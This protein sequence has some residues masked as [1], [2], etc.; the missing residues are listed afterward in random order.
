MKDRAQD[1]YEKEE[2]YSKP[3][4]LV[5]AKCAALTLGLELKVCSKHGTD[6]I[7]F[8]CKFCCFR[9]ATWFCEGNIH[10]C[11]NCRLMQYEGEDLRQKTK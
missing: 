8:K 7:E 2:K 4:D 1:F 6:F 9:V 3:E 11:K 5:C 10:F